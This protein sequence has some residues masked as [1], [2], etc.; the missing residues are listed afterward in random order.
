[1]K[2][3]PLIMPQMDGVQVAALSKAAHNSAASAQD[4]GKRARLNL[5]APTIGA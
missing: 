1:M 2:G 4:L 3:E 5:P